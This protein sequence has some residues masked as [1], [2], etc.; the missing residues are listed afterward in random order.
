MIDSAGTSPQLTPQQ[1]K[2]VLL[3]RSLKAKGMTPGEAAAE[4][5]RHQKLREVGA[6]TADGQP[7]GP[8][9]GRGLG[10]A[11]RSL[12]QGAGD[13]M[14]VTGGAFLGS[15]IGGPKI[16]PTG[17]DGKPGNNYSIFDAPVLAQGV[18]APAVNALPAPETPGEKLGAAVIRG[19]TGGLVG[20]PVGALSGAAA[21]GAGQEVANMGGGDLA[22]LL[23][24]LGL[25]GLVAGLSGV[26]ARSPTG[27]AGKILDQRIAKEGDVPAQV[28]GQARQAAQGQALDAQA[29]RMFAGDMGA[30]APA[31]TMSSGRELLGRPGQELAMQAASEGGPAGRQVVAQ[32]EQQAKGVTRR[33]LQQMTQRL[34][35]RGDVNMEQQLSKDQSAATKPLY[36]AVENKTVKVDDELRAWLDFPDVDRVYAAG[37]KAY[38]T[39][40]AEANGVKTPRKPLPSLRDETGAIRKELPLAALNQLK[41]GLDDLTTSKAGSAQEIPREQSA[42]IQSRLVPIRNLIDRQVPE[43]R[44]ARET[45]QRFEQNKNALRIGQ[46]FF[47]SKATDDEIGRSVST[48]DGEQKGYLKAGLADALAS[49]TGNP[50]QALTD[51]QYL[52]RLRSILSPDEVKDMERIVAKALKEQASADQVV[53]AGSPRQAS[54]SANPWRKAAIDLATRLNRW[55]IKDATMGAVG[56]KEMKPPVRQ[57]MAD[58]LTSSGEGF[59]T[60]ED[61]LRQAQQAPAQNVNMG[62]LGALLGAQQPR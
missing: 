53:A 2:D 61:A 40:P 25:G 62:L 45:A 4:I 32:A 60:Q 48:M 24:S 43:Y 34:G 36:D 26:A 31:P 21:G 27:K 52:A 55:A 54:T 50:A 3:Y 39:R 41:K 5:A 11:G 17:P 8:S 29:D 16:G 12:L 9:L 18:V 37:A 59:L 28:R 6:E 10:I 38:D 1:Y 20:G 22:Q 14:A 19:A 13:L 42:A 15:G 46:E 30:E 44:V 56:G 51:P 47:K 23:A 7:T 57:A 35:G 58:L 33:F 49:K